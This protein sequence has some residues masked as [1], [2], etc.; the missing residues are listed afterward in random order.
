MKLRPHYLLKHHLVFLSLNIN[1]INENLE[2][3][4]VLSLRSIMYMSPCILPCCREAIKI[5]LYQ[6]NYLL[7]ASLTLF[8]WKLK[9]QVMAEPNCTTWWHKE[10]AERCSAY[11]QGVRQITAHLSTSFGWEKCFKLAPPKCRNLM[12]L[13]ALKE[14]LDFVLFSCFFSQRTCES[15]FPL[16]FIS[17]HW[18]IYRCM[19]THSASRWQ[20]LKQLPHF[21]SQ[22]R[23]AHSSLKQWHPKSHNTVLRMGN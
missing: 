19:N 14:C 3:G 10:A 20:Q 17:T 4:L 6:L 12:F 8:V 22:E 16:G 11:L 13:C 2:I 7:P 9:R 23:N 5:L 18:C 1:A 15:R 21:H